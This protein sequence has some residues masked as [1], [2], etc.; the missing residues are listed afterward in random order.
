MGRGGRGRSVAIERGRLQRYH[1]NQLTTTF[2]RVLDRVSKKGARMSSI[3]MH[4]DGEEP[5]QATYR[6][7]GLFITRFASVEHALRFRLAEEINLDLHFMSEILTH[8]FALLCTAVTAVFSKTLKS[9]EERRELKR[10]MS[11][12]RSMNDVRVKV[13]HGQWFPD[14]GGGTVAHASRQNLAWKDTENMAGLLKQQAEQA[15]Q[16]FEALH[17]LLSKYRHLYETRS[18][19]EVM[20]LDFD[21]QLREKELTDEDREMFRNTQEALWSDMKLKS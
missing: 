19:A 3:D 17:I 12:C 2:G 7:I 9:E 14:F 13:V 6:A 11:Q 20:R 18:M 8:D 5:R 1:L 21:A 10:L 16:T 15:G 4:D